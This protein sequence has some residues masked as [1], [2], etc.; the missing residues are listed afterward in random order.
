M[1]DYPIIET[2][3]LLLR[4][5]SLQDSESVFRH[6]SEPEVTRFMDIEPCR[7]IKEAYEIIQYHIDDAGCRYG[8]F[9]KGNRELVGTCGFH[10]WERGIDSRAEIG[11]DLSSEF[12]GQGLMQEALVE[13]LRMGVNIMKLD[14]IEATVE[15]ENIRSQRLLN[16][17][18]FIRQ[19]ELR[20]N[21]YYYI[22][23]EKN[24]VL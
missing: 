17:M 6:F 4:E 3:R 21:L 10:C 11:F 18:R 22:L 1:I 20:D 19:E 15:Q 7:D 9:N 24:M 13:V 12:W 14:V 23:K 5:L 8:L 2:K 16:K